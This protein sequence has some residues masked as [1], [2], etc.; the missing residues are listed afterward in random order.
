M[1][2][3]DNI[4]IFHEEEVNISFSTTIGTNL[5]FFGNR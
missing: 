3:H 2:I 1:C 5:Y 4:L